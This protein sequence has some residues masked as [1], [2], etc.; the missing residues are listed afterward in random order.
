MMV[1]FASIFAITLMASALASPFDSAAEISRRELPV[2]IS[3]EVATS[4]LS[5]CARIPSV[6]IEMCLTLCFSQ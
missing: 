5:Q 4:Y 3:V 2:G 1:A 6:V